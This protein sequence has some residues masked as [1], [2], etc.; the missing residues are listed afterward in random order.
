VEKSR[1]EFM[2][3]TAAGVAA[4]SIVATVPSAVLGANDKIRLAVMGVNGR[5]DG[6]AGEFAQNPNIEVTWI[7]DVDKNAIAK[8]IKTVEKA[9]GN[10]PKGETDIRK[11]LEQKDVDAL[12]IAAP[13]HWHA[14][15]TLM[16]LKAGK[17]VYVEKPCGHNPRE[18]EILIE[19]QKKYGKV[20]QMGNQ[21]R[22]SIH[23]LQ[24]LAKVR[25]GI[26]GRPYM[27][28]AFYAN[29]RGPI[30][31]GK[32]AAVPEW[33]DWELWQGPA[34]RVEYKDNI[35]HYNW[36][37]FWRWGTGEAL[38]NGTHEVDICRWFLDVD[39]PTKVTSTGGRFHYE[40]DW[41]F[42]DTQYIGWEFEDRKA[43]LWE[44]RSCNGTPIKG[45][46]RGAEIYGDNGTLLIDRNG[47]EVYDKKNKL[48]EE[49][50]S[51]EANASMDTTGIGGSMNGAHI[52][53][54]VNA[55]IKNEKQNSP[56]DIGHKSV[57]LCQLGNIAQ[58]KG[59]SLEIDPENGRIVGDKDAMKMWSRDYEPGWEMTL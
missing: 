13:D 6:M 53:N 30:G 48:V 51:K 7:C 21:Q 41:E 3:T 9:A 49:V 5:G 52:A 22:S 58:A 36:H 39:Y 15:A 11:V 27:G 1:R 28:K 25:D 40:D 26:I 43:I 12:Y 4:A 57:L 50:T 55:I 20:V 35:V 37:W 34:P 32:P 14:P 2:K 44:G 59:R 24:A 8:T 10:K 31:V 38:N 33:L 29:S 45:R 17:H 56:I 23:T 54:F 47:Y 46:G 18:G 16:A 19:A 42:Y